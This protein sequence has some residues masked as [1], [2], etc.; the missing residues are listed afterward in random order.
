MIQ[1]S[2]TQDLDKIKDVVIIGAGPSGLFAAFQCSLLKLSVALVDS[3]PQAG[4][5]IA[6]L[7]PEKNIL[8]VPGFSQITGGELAQKLVEQANQFPINWYL[9]SQVQ[10]MQKENDVW[11]LVIDSGQNIQARSI[12]IAAGGGSFNPKKPP[13]KNIEDYESTSV[14]YAVQNPIQYKGK[15]IVIIG[16]GDSAVDWAIQ[17]TQ[18]GAYVTLVHRRDKFRALPHHVETIEKYAR[19]GRLN[20]QTGKQIYNIKGKAPF[21]HHVQITDIDGYV[22]DIKADHLMIFMGL[23]KDLGPISNWGLSESKTRIDVNPITLQTSEEGI[24][25]VGD[26]AHWEGKLPLIVTGFGEAAIAA[27]NAFIFVNPDEKLS[28]LHSTSMKIK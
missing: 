13:I 8:D 19:E 7:Y 23:S 3:L 9:K 5:Q 18:I 20:L 26:I 16:G 4:G 2:K 27:R 15:N 6:T 22:E 10:R 21:I 11:N 17:L 12:I 1:S 28:K 25:A 14:H 24:F